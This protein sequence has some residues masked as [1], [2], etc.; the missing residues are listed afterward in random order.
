M[1]MS[2][3]SVAPMANLSYGQRLVVWTARCWVHGYMN[4]CP[5]FQLLH[6]IYLDVGAPEAVAEVDAFFS[7]L[8]TS[9]RAR[10]SFGDPGCRCETCRSVGECE[11]KLVTC[12]A[13]LQ[14]GCH[15]RATGIL[16]RWLPATAAQT[17]LIPARRWSI[18]LFAQNL[19]LETIPRGFHDDGPAGLCGTQEIAGRSVH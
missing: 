19:L 14:K 3:S 18:A 12:L 11:A 7:T 9:G 17:A 4:R 2:E 1:S 5:V 13:S 8:A 15:T 16:D 6:D 10:L